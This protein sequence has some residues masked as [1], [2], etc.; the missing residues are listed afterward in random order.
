M[1]KAVLRRFHFSPL[2]A[3]ASEPLTG[4]SPWAVSSSALVVLSCL[5]T[6]ALPWLSPSLLLRCRVSARWRMDTS[7]RKSCSAPLSKKCAPTVSTC[8]YVGFSSLPYHW[9]SQP[10]GHFSN[11]FNIRM[12]IQIFIMVSNIA[13]ETILDVKTLFP[14]SCNSYPS[15]S[16]VYLEKLWWQ[17]LAVLCVMQGIP[18]DVEMPRQPQQCESWGALSLQ[19]YAFCAQYRVGGTLLNIVPGGGCHRKWW[20]VRENQFSS[21]WSLELSPGGNFAPMICHSCYFYVLILTVCQ[22]PTP[23]VYVHVTLSHVGCPL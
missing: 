4:F 15:D 5:A 11:L 1:A 22:T 7:W 9:V 18:V 6:E 16:D 13:L 23:P 19:S 21:S 2:F 17:C 12:I 3:C 10:I 20:P 8:P 14:Q